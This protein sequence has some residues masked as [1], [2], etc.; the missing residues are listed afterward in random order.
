VKEGDLDLLRQIAEHEKTI[1]WSKPGAELGWEWRDVRISPA[2]LTRFYLEGLLDNPFK[3]N[4]CTGYQLSEEGKRVL[5][6]GEDL[7]EMP[8]E[9]KE[10]EI[11]DDLFSVIEGYEDI[12]DLVKTVLQ[13]EK[14]VHLLFTG[15]PASAKTMFLMELARLGA[16]YVLGSQSSRAGIAQ[17]LFETEPQVLLVDEIDRIG[18]KDISVLLSL[19]ATGIVSE[20]KHGKQRSS[21][22]DTRVFAASNTLRMPPELISRFMVLEF[23][24]YGL[25]DFLTVATNVLVRQEGITPDMAAYIAQR[26][27]QLSSRFPDPRQAV[28]V[29]RLAKTREEAD[30]VFDLLRRY[31]AGLTR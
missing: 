22:L 31:G 2:I 26:T 8:F 4:S 1:D 24:P 27:W 9:K 17:L 23:K 19:M 11:P 13:N 6:V 28:R 30:S 7:T 20:T 10:L 18:T 14:P 21:S 16:P 3:S 15:V 29:A 12:K 25:N 5:E